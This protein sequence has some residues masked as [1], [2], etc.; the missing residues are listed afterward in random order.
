[1]ARAWAVRDA[2]VQRTLSAAQGVAVYQRKSGGRKV[3]EG[4]EEEEQE[5]VGVERLGNGGLQARGGA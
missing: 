1:M 2:Y 4:S 5:I 3:G